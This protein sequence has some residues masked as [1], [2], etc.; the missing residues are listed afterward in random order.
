MRAV[1][2]EPLLVLLFHEPLYFRHLHTIRFLE[3]RASV[4]DFPEVDNAT[5]TPS[6]HA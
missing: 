6:G 4:S 2:K 3:A 1:K 5:A